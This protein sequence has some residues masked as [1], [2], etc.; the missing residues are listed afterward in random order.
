MSSSHTHL[1][2][3]VLLLTLVQFGLHNEIQVLGVVFGVNDAEER[4]GGFVVEP[5]GREEE[6]LISPFVLQ[7]SLEKVW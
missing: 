7:A 4:A 5:E 3:L 2:V 6:S 1:H